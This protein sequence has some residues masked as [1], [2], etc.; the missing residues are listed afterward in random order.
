M[1]ELI[2][3]MLAKVRPAVRSGDLGELSQQ[4]EQVVVLREAVFRYLQHVGR[5]EFSDAEA[6]EHARLVAAIGEIETMSAAISRELLPLAQNLAETNVTPSRETA[7]LM[8]RLFATIQA[9]AQAALRAL[10]AQDEAAARK[11]VASRDAI[12]ELTSGFYRLQAGRL[13][14]DDPDRLVKHRVQLEMLDRLR[15]LYSVAE[16]MAVSVLPRNLPVDEPSA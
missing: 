11:V 14:T 9:S 7:D 3:G 12:L 16:H 10:V 15:R 5:A 6:D 8:A 4:H 2:E 1:A 13:A